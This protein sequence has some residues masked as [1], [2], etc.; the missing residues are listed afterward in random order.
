MHRSKEPTSV[1][2]GNPQYLSISASPSVLVTPGTRELEALAQPTV[3][4]ISSPLFQ[5]QPQLENGTA[6][7]IENLALSAPSSQVSYEDQEIYGMAHAPLF[8]SP[9][10]PTIT[11]RSRNLISH[12][13]PCP[14]C[15]KSFLYRYEYK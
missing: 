5:P 7:S 3:A 15:N 13:I 6:V 8:P 2:P 1:C 14:K 10:N 4:H 11:A 9:P 12:P